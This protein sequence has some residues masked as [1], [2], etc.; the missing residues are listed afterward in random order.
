MSSPDPEIVWPLPGHLFKQ[1]SCPFSFF[2]F[3]V[4]LQPTSL[5]STKVPHTGPL[6]ENSSTCVSHQRAC[7]GEDAACFLFL[8]AC[9]K[10]NDTHTHRPTTHRSTVLRFVKLCLLQQFCNYSNCFSN[11]SVCFFLFYPPLLLW[12]CRSSALPLR[13]MWRADSNKMMTPS[14]LF[15]A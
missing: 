13:F 14:S 5:H 8:P 1:V 2:F 15:S 12:F 3:L 10:N 6:T 7:W 9:D 4:H 11:P